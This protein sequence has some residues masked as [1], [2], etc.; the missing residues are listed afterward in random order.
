MF[1]HISFS[2]FLQCC[3]LQPITDDSAEFMNATAN[4]RRSD[5]SSLKHWR[6]CTEFIS[7]TNSLIIFNEVQM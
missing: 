3:A 4:Q 6:Q 7:L 2:V 1:H 5:E